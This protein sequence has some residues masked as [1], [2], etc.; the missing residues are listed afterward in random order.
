MLFRILPFYGIGEECV[1]NR[2]RTVMS[3]SVFAVFTEQVPSELSNISTVRYILLGIW[4]GSI[5]TD[6]VRCFATHR[7][8]LPILNVL[9]G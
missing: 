4:Q 3:R 8:L 7:L 6:K 9:L 5:A 2:K 1:H